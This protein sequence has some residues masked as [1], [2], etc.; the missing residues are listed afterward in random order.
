MD[1]AMKDI[2]KINKKME[3][4]MGIEGSEST[5]SDYG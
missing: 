5:P 1:F 3:K 2:K 4:A